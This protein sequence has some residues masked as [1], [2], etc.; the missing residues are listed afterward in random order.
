MAN[1]LWVRNNGGAWNANGSADPVTGVGGIDI[2]ALDGLELFPIVQGSGLFGAT[3]TVNFGASA[4]GYTPP[5]GF[6]AWGASVTLDPAKLAGAG[7]PPLTNGNLS[8][9]PSAS[10]CACQATT[11]HT[12]GRYYWELTYTSL[13][14]IA[15]F[16]GGGVGREYPGLDYST[17][18]NNNGR[19]SALD[20]NGGV[21]IQSSH[22]LIPD[23]QARL[24]VLGSLISAAL[25]PQY[26]PGDVLSWAVTLGDAPGVPDPACGGTHTASSFTAAWT[27]SGAAADTY[28]LQY[29][30]V[31]TVPFTTISGITAISHLITG[32]LSGTDYEFKVKALNTSGE[33]AYSALF[34]CSTDSLGRSAKIADLWFSH[35]TAFVDLSVAATRRQFITSV[36]A[37]Q[38]LGTSGEAPLGERPD[39]F[40]TRTE[41]QPADFFANNMGTGGTFTITGG[42]LTATGGTDHPPC[43]F[44]GLPIT[45]PPLVALRWS[46]DRGKTY[47]NPLYQ[48]MGATGQYLVQPT[49]NRLGLARDRVFEV[50]GTIPG[51][52][53]INGAWLDPEPKK[54]KS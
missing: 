22:P 20:A 17:W 50:F 29:R 14:A 19:Y 24:G 8:F 11:G 1:L 45:D 53:A 42:S 54:L 34:P 21:I 48:T 51:K 12:T 7:V 4:F 27:P 16:T 30:K 52:F 36:G 28:T 41:G 46:D 10:Y 40:L 25:F 13:S 23:Y 32:L 33:S 47:S 9:K 35:T 2:G 5:T 39:V 15:N 49:W 26:Q 6:A 43:A 38:D 3:Q 18:S 37:A 31:G 44:G